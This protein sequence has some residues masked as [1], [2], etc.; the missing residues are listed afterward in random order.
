MKSLLNEQQAVMRSGPIDPNAITGAFNAQRIAKQIYDAK[1]LLSDDEE[2]VEPAIRA[3]KNIN[4][5]ILVNK[6]L[7]KLTGGRGMGE[8]LGSFLD[9]NP[10][11][12]IASYLLEFIPKNHWNWTIKKIVPWNDFRTVAQNDPS[13]Y[14]KWRAGETGIGEEKALIKLMAGPYQQAWSKWSSLSAGEQLNAWWKDNGHTVLTT[15][16]IVTAFVPVVGWAVSAGIGLIDAKMYYDEKDT[17]TAGIVAIFAMLPVVGK[18]VNKIPGI[19]QLG[20]KGMSALAKKLNVAKTTAVKFSAIEMEVINEL[21]KNDKFVKQQIESYLKTGIAKST[22]QIIASKAKS[23]AKNGLLQ[24]VKVGTPIAGTLGVAVGYN[25]A[26]DVA[27]MAT[28]EQ[29]QQQVLADLEQMYNQE[30]K[31]KK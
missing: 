29:V 8:Y 7:Q 27:T 26:Y 6:E 17:K 16:Q 23:Y 3:I 24:F 11:L 30:M 9:I 21:A 20:A 12:N 19:N 25:Y 18:I 10:R 28:P 31:N 13:I 1:G 4:Q 22:K 5:Y 2:K 15:L 14:D